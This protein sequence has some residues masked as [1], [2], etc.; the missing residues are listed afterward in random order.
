MEL[1]HKQLLAGDGIDMHG[2]ILWR[3]LVDSK[4]R[5]DVR[6]N[7]QSQSRDSVYGESLLL[8]AIRVNRTWNYNADLDALR[9]ISKHHGLGMAARS[10]RPREL[11]R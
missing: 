3:E 4:P 5:D 7:R 9:R 6:A 2:V 11:R 8:R 10:L 1:D